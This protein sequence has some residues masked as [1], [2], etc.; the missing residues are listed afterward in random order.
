M[1]SFRMEINFVDYRRR[2]GKLMQAL[3]ALSLHDN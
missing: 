2:F 1:L 3:F